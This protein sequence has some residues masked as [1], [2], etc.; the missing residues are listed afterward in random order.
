MS[1]SVKCGFHFPDEPV[2]LIGSQNECANDP[3]RCVAM[4]PDQVVC[5]W[6]RIMPVIV[7]SCGYLHVPR[8]PSA[9]FRSAFADCD[10]Y[11][12]YSV[13]DAWEVG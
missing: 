4:L 6:P 9:A 11:R 13:V 5:T 8:Y 10:A 3:K 12:R 2:M 7:A 1:G